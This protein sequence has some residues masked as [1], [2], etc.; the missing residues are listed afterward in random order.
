MSRAPHQ[1]PLIIL[2][3]HNRRLVAA[4]QLFCDVHRLNK[5]GESLSRWYSAAEMKAIRKNALQAIKNSSTYNP[6]GE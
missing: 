2:R 3:R 4:L 6:K 5:N 1:N